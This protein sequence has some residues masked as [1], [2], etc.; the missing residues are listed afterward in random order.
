MSEHG[1]RSFIGT[2]LDFCTLRNAL[3][4]DTRHFLNSEWK[5]DG[6]LDNVI[7]KGK[8]VVVH[9]RWTWSLGGA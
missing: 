7:H 3:A 8:I 2:V 1:I 6:G 5:I 9:S 4:G